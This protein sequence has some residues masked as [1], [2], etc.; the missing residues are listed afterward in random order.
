MKALPSGSSESLGQYSSPF[1]PFS[2]H[3]HFRLLFWEI[4]HLH[5]RTIV[6]IITHEPC[7]HPLDEVFHTTSPQFLTLQLRKLPL[8]SIIQKFI[9]RPYGSHSNLQSFFYH[10]SLEPTTSSLSKGKVAW[11]EGQRPLLSLHL[12][13]ILPL[14][15]LPLEN[16][17]YSVRGTCLN[18][19]KVNAKNKSNG[20]G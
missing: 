12:V 6:Q 7:G 15:V 20:T 10:S 5:Y 18:Y 13:Q 4:S 16:H 19:K 11:Q 2:I 14:T 8:S 17:L 3:A 9:Q 1:S